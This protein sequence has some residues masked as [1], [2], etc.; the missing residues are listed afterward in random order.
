MKKLFLLLLTAFVLVACKE[1]PKPIPPEQIAGK[2]AVEY[3]G[4]LQR[5]D[6]RAFVDGIYYAK[7]IP[8]EYR[9]LLEKNAEN[10]VHEQDSLRHGLK[11]IKLS[12]ADLMKNDTTLAAVY[13]LLQY[14]DSTSEEVLVPMVKRKDVWYMK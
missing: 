2:A 1:K 13:L 11:S 10:V 14:G 12:K 3:Y 6:F 4:Y 9:E 5:H 7:P 8:K